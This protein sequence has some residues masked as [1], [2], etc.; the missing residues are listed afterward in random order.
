MSEEQVLDVYDSGKVNQKTGQTYKNIYLKTKVDKATGE[1][2][3]G[4]KAGHHIV[5]QKVFEKGYEF[6][7]EDYS[8]FSCLVKY[9][10]H[11]VTFWLYDKDHEKYAAIGGVDDF[12]KIEA[13]AYTYKTKGVEKKG[14]ALNF[15]AVE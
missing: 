1:V 2:F 4:L 11:E 12:V 7:G 6:K 10:D 3:Q 9:G 15:S 8:S 5:V 13:E 14:L